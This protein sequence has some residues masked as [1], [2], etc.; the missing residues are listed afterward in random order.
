MKK[1]NLFKVIMI[2]MLVLLVATWIFPITYF[3]SALAEEEIV[4]AGAFDI[5]G[6]LLITLQVFGNV[7]IY[8]LVVGG[9]YGVLHKIS[10]YRNMLDSIVVK[11]KDM[12]DIFLGA[13]MVLLAIMS[14]MAGLS[15]ALLFIFPL[16]ISIILLMGYNKITAAMT[17][18]GAVTIGLMGTVFSSSNII[19][20]TVAADSEI[21]TKI[22]LLVIGLVLLIFNVLNYAKKNKIEKQEEGSYVP[23]KSENK[24]KV[25]PLV[26]IIDLILLVMILAFISWDLLKVNIFTEA[27]NNVYSFKVFG[28]EL[29]G[30]LLGD[31]SSINA[32]GAWSLRELVTVIVMASGL[33]AFIYK[34]KFN[35]FLKNF[36]DGA[37]RAIKPAVIV[38][39][40]YTILVISVYHP[41]L[42]TV[43]KPLIG[44]TDGLNVIVM[45]VVGFITSVFSVEFRFFAGADMHILPYVLSLYSNA[46]DITLVSIIWQAVYGFTMLFAPT[47]VILMA[48]LSY[49]HIPYGKWMKAIYKLVLELL[50]V[51]LIVFLVLT[52]I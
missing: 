35:D 48:T 6:Y 49:L 4:R 45:T 37:K 29:F 34:V 39:L 14:S 40:L 20:L 22:A 16:L 7:A 27:Y 31:K 50:A 32:F 3:S 1:H 51:L 17:T 18:V 52:F 36:I 24:G 13:V 41:V 19:G 30:S 46:N 23:A 28:F 5:L 11:F 44:L 38:V 8:V 42:L 33:I 12:E 26:V 15:L 9:F 21:L 43:L 2:T 10:A 25:W 47:S